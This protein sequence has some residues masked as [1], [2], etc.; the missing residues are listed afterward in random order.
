MWT[1]WPQAC[2]TPTVFPSSSVGRHLAGVGE[3]GLLDDGQGVEVGADQDGRPRPVLE[4]ADDAELADAGRHLRPGLPQ[5]LGDPP[6]GLRLLEG[7][8]G[9][10]VQ[11]VVEGDQLVEMLA[12]PGLVRVGR[13]SAETCRAEAEAAIAGRAGRPD[14]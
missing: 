1:S 11:M 5:L 4:H 9:V 13:T 12:G 7:E 14:A 6:R 3:A 10:A 8:L 2:I